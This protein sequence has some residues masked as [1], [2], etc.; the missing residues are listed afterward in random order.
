MDLPANP[1][2]LVVH[3]IVIYLPVVVLPDKDLSRCGA[4]VKVSVVKVD[5]DI[6]YGVLGRN[7]VFECKYELTSLLARKM[8]ETHF[9]GIP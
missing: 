5:E 2:L 4:R 7:Q 6:S 3:T 8:V 9:L 1:I